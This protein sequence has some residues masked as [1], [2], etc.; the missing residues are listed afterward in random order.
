MKITEKVNSATQRK[1]KKIQ[2]NSSNLNLWRLFFLFSLP[3]SLIL[4]ICFY[5]ADVKTIFWSDR[6]IRYP[7]V[8]GYVVVFIFLSIY[9]SFS[10]ALLYVFLFLVKSLLQKKD[11]SQRKKAGKYSLIFLSNQLVFNLLLILLCKW[12]TKIA[13][14]MLIFFS[15]IILNSFFIHYFFSKP[16]M[17]LLIK[18]YPHYFPKVFYQEKKSLFKKVQTFDWAMIITLILVNFWILSLLFYLKF[19]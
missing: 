14:I 5:L 7:F 10:I 8:R 17:Q 9:I 16:V 13:F 19:I 1:V 18:K 3:F 12:R 2:N 6:S 4:T 11:R 15:S